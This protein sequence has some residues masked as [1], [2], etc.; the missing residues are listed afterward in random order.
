MNKLNQPNPILFKLSCDIGNIINDFLTETA[1]NYEKLYLA[2]LL[3]LNK[4]YYHKH[5]LF[6]DYYDYNCKK[7]QI[8]KH[9]IHAESLFYFTKVIG[10]NLAL[11]NTL[12]EKPT[13]MHHLLLEYCQ[14]S[15]DTRWHGS[16]IE[17]DKTTTE[18]V[19]DF[20]TAFAQ[21][22]AVQCQKLNNNYSSI[23][24]SRRLEFGCYWFK[25][26]DYATK[27]AEELSLF[28]V[29][30]TIPTPL[31]AQQK[32]PLLLA[33][34]LESLN[35]R[36]GL[37]RS[38]GLPPQTWLDHAISVDKLKQFKQLRQEAETL[39]SQGMNAEK[40]YQSAFEK[41]HVDYGG[42]VAGF[43]G[44]AEFLNSDISQRIF[45]SPSCSA[46]ENDAVDRIPDE[47]FAEDYAYQ[48]ADFLA[49]IANYPHDFDNVTEYV[50]CKI[51]APGSQ[52]FEITELLSDEFFH[53]LVRQN[54]NY[55]HLSDKK[56][57]D[58]VHEQ[59][60]RIFRKHIGE[61]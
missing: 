18:N 49:L 43:S 58:K 57:I 33:R 40:A 38:C 59:L 16:I 11:A 15:Q 53:H 12:E 10:R 44:F 51:I 14:L 37:L 39:I 34:I 36:Y 45:F 29:I 50:F 41:L 5:L 31:I 1:P 19:A 4:T 13:N 56:L 27:V 42:S 52:L 54:R 30:E 60:A 55:A 25:V 3:T 26:H 6:K 32:P 9:K 2:I 24:K 23:S 48:H 17:R 61:R 21:K 7:E 8:N 20:F 28:Q 47:S 22:L 35:K 46:E